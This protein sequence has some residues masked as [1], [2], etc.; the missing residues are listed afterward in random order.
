MNGLTKSISQVIKG[1][2]KAFYTFP[3]SIA[4]AAG[5][6]L[7]TIVRIHLEWPQQEAYNFLF[8]C[9]HWAFALGAVFGL[10]AVTG[11]QSRGGRHAKDFLIANLATGGV[12]AAALGLLLAFGKRLPI[13]TYERATRMSEMAV[14]RMGVAVFISLMAFIWLAG[15]PKEKSD[16]SRAYFMTHKAFFIALLYGLVLMGGTS[17]VA[18]AFQALLYRDMSSKVY[19][20]LATLSGFTAFTVFAGYFPSFKQGEE[21]P[22]R[23]IAQNHPRF[24]EVLFGYI[25]VPIVIALTMVLLL[26]TGRTVLTGDWPDF[27]RLSVIAAWYA[28]GGIWLHIMVTHYDTAVTRFYRRAYPIAALVILAFEARAL[29]VQ[30]GKSG[31]KTE[32]YFFGLIWVV[33][34]VAVVL[35]LVKKAKAHPVI[36]AAVCVACAIAVFPAVNYRDMPVAAQVNRLETLLTRNSILKDGA[37]TPAVI[38]PNEDTRIAVT[39]AVNFVAYKQEAKLPAW[40]PKNLQQ[41]DV[42]KANFGFEQTW[43]KYEDNFP[44]RPTEVMGTYLNLPAGVLEIDGYQWAANVRNFESKMGTSSVT[45]NGSKGRYDVYWETNM[46]ES[47]PPLLKINLNDKTV[48]EQNMNIFFDRIAKKYPPGQGDT[49]ATLEDMMLELE[50]DEIKVLLVFESVSMSVDTKRDEISYWIYLNAMYL[51]EK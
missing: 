12:T 39:D 9:L 50:T 5:F 4:C 48:L 25:M 47:V 46:V 2:A 14:A 27:L 49:R 51:S 13:E 3:A 19:M 45:F 28:A 17:G 40:M 10:A 34:V 1:A 21:D 15:Y 23:E 18:G 41:N 16:F 32:E 37:L 11:A 31:L 38:E 36:V 44:G 33:A 7:V 8:G 26:W 29:L 43:P 6:A 35:L 30:L 24:I 20:Y 42:F 22:H